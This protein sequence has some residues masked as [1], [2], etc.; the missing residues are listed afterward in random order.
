MKKKKS[1]GITEKVAAQ[2][3]HK[4]SYTL[5]LHMAV[6]LTILQTLTLGHCTLTQLAKRV[7]IFH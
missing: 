3:M 2:T 6:L 4:H 7:V 5:E 1:P